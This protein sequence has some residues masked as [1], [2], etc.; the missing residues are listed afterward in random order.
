MTIIL[1]LAG[2]LVVRDAVRRLAEPAVAVAP[3]EMSGRNESIAVAAIAPVTLRD[4][5][6]VSLDSL[7]AGAVS[8]ATG[9]SPASAPARATAR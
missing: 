1:L 4:R 6:A 8:P 3:V 9:E 5:A 7:F 2:T